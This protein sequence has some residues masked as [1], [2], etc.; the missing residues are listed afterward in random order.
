LFE[1]YL[2]EKKL[3]Y[4]ERTAR[5]LCDYE[6]RCKMI[7]LCKIIYIIYIPVIASKIMII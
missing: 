5:F 2:V 3:Y 7:K 4:S 6:K 1:E